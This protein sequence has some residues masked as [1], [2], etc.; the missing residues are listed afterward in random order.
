MSIPLT[1]SSPTKD[2]INLALL[3]HLLGIFTSFVGALVLWIMKKDE[4]AFVGQH[5]LEALNFQITIA[6]AFAICMVLT[7]ILIGVF[8]IPLVYAANVIFCI[9][10]AMAASKG[11]EYRYPFAVRLLK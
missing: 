6:I 2:E 3:S 4:S 1:S 5:A 11:N 10:G 8:F 7:F 9:L